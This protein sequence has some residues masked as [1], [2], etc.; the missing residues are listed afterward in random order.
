MNRRS[1]PACA[2]RYPLHNGM[3]VLPGGA[4]V[5]CEADA[6]MKRFDVALTSFLDVVRKDKA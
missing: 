6:L 4:F 3:H 2:E 5:L 1:C